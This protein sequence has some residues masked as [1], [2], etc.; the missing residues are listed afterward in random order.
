MSYLI[1]PR[2]AVGASGT[3]NGV[4]GMF[5]VWYLLNEISCWYAYW[6]FGLAGG[7]QF[8]ISS[9]WMVLL[10]AVF[11]IVGLIYGVGNV[12]YV[13]HLVGLVAGLTLAVA[14]L[15]TGWVKME[16]GERSLLEVLSGSDE[17]ARSTKA[18]RRKTTRR[19]Q[20]PRIR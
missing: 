10:W 19:P 16:R 5:V 20:D 11:D 8:S 9:Y 6:W 14:M 3:I 12:G 18:T 2:P 15:K 7:G 1:E 17:Q 4:V 13:A